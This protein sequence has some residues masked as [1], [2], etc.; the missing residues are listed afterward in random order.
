[1]QANTTYVITASMD[2][3]VDAR[4]SGLRI[5]SGTG[6]L[7]TTLLRAG[8][9]DGDNAVTVT[10][11]SLVAGLYGSPANGSSAD[12][13]ANGVIDVTDVSLAAG[14]YNLIGPTGW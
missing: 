7:G 8:D 9:I 11:V 6:E 14:N 12:L 10:D 1:L 5:V 3:F 2:G 4:R 13:N